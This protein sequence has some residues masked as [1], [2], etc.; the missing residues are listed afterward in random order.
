M[1]EDVNFIGA[2]GTDFL[3]SEVFKHTQNPSEKEEIREYT[4]HR[5]A[6]NH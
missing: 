2:F 4:F 3:Q 5:F 6:K 1:P